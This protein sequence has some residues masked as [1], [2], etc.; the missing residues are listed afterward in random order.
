MYIVLG[1]TG[2]VGSS[3]A[4]TLLQQ[5]EK[6]TVITHD[7]KKI[8]DWEKRGAKTAIVDVLDINSLRE[9]FKT[10]TRLF[11]LNPPAKP[12]TDTV[13]EEK[14]TLFAILD[15]LE[16]SGIKKVIAESTYGAQSDESIGDLFV[17]FEMEERLKKMDLSATIIR[18]AYYMSNWDTALETAQ[19]E[20]VIHT[21]YPADFKLPMVAPKDIGEI[22]AKLLSEPIEKS[23]LHYVEGPEE[24][25]SADVAEAFANA[26]GKPVKTIE[27]PKDQWLDALRQIGF[28]EKAAKSMAAMTEI[29]LE[30]KYEKPQSPMRGATTINKYI[31]NLVLKQNKQL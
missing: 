18:A 16:D 26:L 17:L 25:S 20:G 27:T 1:G 2:H 29:T 21:L 6:V 4:A 30:Q 19:K 15:A 12:S 24:Y 28:S 22:A 10:G 3:V 13:A 8:K 14:K 23:G 7:N 31:E 9:V 5:G 11:L